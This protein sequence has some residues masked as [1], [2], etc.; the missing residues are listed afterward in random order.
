M[1]HSNRNIYEHPRFLSVADFLRF[2][3][4]ADS[5][6][7]EVG[8]EV[9]SFQAFVKGVREWITIDMFGKPTYKIDISKRALA[10]P[11]SDGSIDIVVCTQVLEH[12]TNTM[13]FLNEVH[14]ILTPGG[15][16]IISVP[17][18]V[19]LKSRIQT[20][21]GK[22]PTMAASGDLGPDYG[23]HG[24]IVKGFVVGGHV[25]DYDLPRLEF[26]LSRSRLKILKKIRTP[27]T[28]RMFGKRV[29]V[30]GWLI[31]FKLM[32]NIIVAAG[33]M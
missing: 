21:C 2:N 32:D 12:L 3:V 19:G 22:I 1:P 15:Q 14:R 31:P 28:F 7:L 16:I 5:K 13:S 10:L 24:S 11:L 29:N 9:A 23:T 8:G 17:N 18:M 27:F 25:I 20:M 30:P 26:Q 33:K 4:K 6:V